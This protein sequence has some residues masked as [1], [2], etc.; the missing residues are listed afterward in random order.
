MTGRHAERLGTISMHFIL[1]ADA[2]SAT[3]ISVAPN[4]SY[5]FTAERFAS[6]RH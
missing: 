2:A 1:Q 4:F 3:Q 6:R 5:P